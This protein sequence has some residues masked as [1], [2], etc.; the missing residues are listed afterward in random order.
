MTDRFLLTLENPWSTL[1]SLLAGIAEGATEPIDDRQFSQLHSLGLVDGTAA[2]PA[3]SEIGRR[4]YLA[5]YV[6]E[7]KVAARDVLGELLQ[8]QFVPIT[9]CATL[10]GSG[11]K[12]VAGALRLL[13]QITKSPDDTKGR[14]WLT[15][16]N[17]GG[18]VTYNQKSP[19]LRIAFNP[20]ELTAPD[21]ADARERVAGHVLSPETPYTNLMVVKQTIRAARGFLWWYEQHMPA[22]VLEVLMS[23]LD[24][25][26]VTEVRILS[27]PANVT[28]ALKDEFGRF[29][30]EMA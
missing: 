5:K 26:K 19:T 14:R 16:M 27:G 22:K 8:G 4:Y 28:D 15:L 20:N 17:S 2:S 10:W 25:E 11:S 18:L 21:E 1:E 12:P 9:F 30:K 3:L 6:H 7:D 24:G 29:V 13:R 23:E